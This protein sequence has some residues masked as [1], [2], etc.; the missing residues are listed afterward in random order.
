MLK[1]T[2]HLEYY[3]GSAPHN[4]H[5]GFYSCNELLEKEIVLT[6]KDVRCLRITPLTRLA[7]FL[8]GSAYLAT[9]EL[10]QLCYIYDGEYQIYVRVIERY[11]NM[12]ELSDSLSNDLYLFVFRS[13]EQ[14]KTTRNTQA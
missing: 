5:E 11:D 9:D 2:Y 7:S 14:P 8:V 13:V 4:K 1:Y 12:F 3:I 6:E 10:R